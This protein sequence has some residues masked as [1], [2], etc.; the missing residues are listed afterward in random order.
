ML[1]ARGAL[2]GVWVGAP[3]LAR[4]RRGVGT[5]EGFDLSASQGLFGGANG[6]VVLARDAAVMGR[7]EEVA[8]RQPLLEFDFAQPVERG[9]GC[10]SEE[11]PPG[12]DALV[13]WMRFDML[14]D[15]R[16]VVWRVCVCGLGARCCLS[17]QVEHAPSA[18]GH[19]Q[20]GVLQGIVLLPEGAGGMLRATMHGDLQVKWHWGGTE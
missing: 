2:W 10:F 7:V 18:A 14:G 5:V 15:G 12:C 20:P 11:I 8:P 3:D 19:V 4:A 13:V 16:L 17:A 9:V 1:P 6:V